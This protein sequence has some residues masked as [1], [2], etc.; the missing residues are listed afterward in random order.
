MPVLVDRDSLW[1]I[2]DDPNPLTAVPWLRASHKWR[3]YFVGYKFP[4]PLS[5][6]V[7]AIFRTAESPD[8]VARALDTLA[9]G[10]SQ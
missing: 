2:S 3:G 5:K 8:Q 4:I 1:I 6:E 7:K 10:V 9:G